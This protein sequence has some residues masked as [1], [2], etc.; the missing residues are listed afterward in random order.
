M[1]RPDLTALRDDVG[2]LPLADE[3]LPA[4]MQALHYFTEMMQYELI[5][6]PA[7]VTTQRPLQVTQRTT[8]QRTTTQ[9]ITTQ[10]TTTTQQT[11]KSTTPKTTRSTTQRPSTTQTTQRTTIPQDFPYVTEINIW[12]K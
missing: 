12:R 4:V 8:T 7:V 5:K 6:N 1:P 10:P 11:T 2:T 9:R 3:Y